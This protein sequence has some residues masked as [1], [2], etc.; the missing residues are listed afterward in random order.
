MGTGR[1]VA[2][3][4]LLRQLPNSRFTLFLKHRPVVEKGSAGLFDLQL[5]GHI[6]KG[7]IFPFNLVTRLFYPVKTG[8]SH[9]QGNA[10]LYVS[11]GTGTW[12]PPV[13]FLAPPEITVIDL[14]HGPGGKDSK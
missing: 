4:D 7:Q 3:K 13:R 5:S 14:V 10:A 12:G 11:R 8:F 2:E 6:H 1:T 9:L